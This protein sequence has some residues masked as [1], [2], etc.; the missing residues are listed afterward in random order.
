M[1]VIV[2]LEKPDVFDVSHV[3][4]EQH[5]QNLELNQQVEYSK[6][7]RLEV[8]QQV[9][10]SDFHHIDASFCCSNSVALI[11]QL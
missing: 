11:E 3:K 8:N 1:L 9:K 7:C 5:S 6:L 10:C 2:S 4:T